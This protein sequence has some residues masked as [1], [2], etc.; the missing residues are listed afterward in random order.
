METQL[1][2][3]INNDDDFRSILDLNLMPTALTNDPISLWG[4]NKINAPEVWNKITNLTTVVVGV[5][6]TGVDYRHEDLIQNMW[7]NSQEIAGNGIDDDNNGYI[8]DFYGYDFYKSNDSDPR[9]GNSHGTHV[10]GI[11][12]AVGNNNLGVVGV[13]PNAQIMALKFFSDSGDNGSYYDAAE[14]IYYAVKLK[15]Q[16]DLDHRTGAN[17][18]VINASFGGTG[19]DSS[20]NNAIKAAENAGILIVAAAGNN[21]RDTDIN[22]FYPASANY[23]NVIAVGA[24]N[25]NDRRAS[26]SNYG[27]T[28]VDVF[29]PGQSIISTLPKNKYGTKSGTSMAAPHVAGIAS[30]L[31]SINNNL[32]PEQVKEALISSSV[33]ISKLNNLSVSD[34]VVNANAAV[35]YVID[36]FGVSNTNN[37][38]VTGDDYYTIDQ[39]SYLSIN[40]I[41]G[42]LANDYDLDNNPLT[43]SLVND[44][45]Q[46]ILKLNSDGSFDYTPNSN[47]LGTDSFI[48]RVNDGQGGTKTGLVTLTTAPLNHAPIANNDNY[49]LS[50]DQTLIISVENGVL[51]NDSDVDGDSLTV[52]LVNN[53][54]KGT[55]VLSN[56]GSFN[57]TPNADINGIDSFTYQASDGRGNFR[58]ATVTLNINPINDAPILVQ[59]INDVM[60]SV[61]T[62][63]NYE[64]PINTFTDIDGDNLTYTARLGNGDNLPNWLSFDASSRTFSGNIP[65]NSPKSL[66]IKV[67]ASDGNLSATDQFTLNV[68]LSTPPPVIGE[69]GRLNLSSNN[70]SVQLQGNYINPVVFVLTPSFNESDSV[71]PRLTNISSNQF[72]VSLKETTG[73]LKNNNFNSNHATENVSYLVLET[74]NYILASGAQLK[75]GEIKANG[76]ILKASKN[77]NW[78]DIKFSDSFEA[79][80][81]VL[82]Q[83]QTN[84]EAGYLVTRQR[85]ITPTGVQIGLQKEE[86]LNETIPSSETIGYLAISQ[87]DG[88]WG[89]NPYL[90]QNTTNAANS[91]WLTEK[92]T[93]FSQTPELFASLSTFNGPDTVNLRYT[94][95]GN[96]SVQF[97]A[98]EEQSLGSE[99]SHANEGL[100]YLLLQG[101]G[102]LTGLAV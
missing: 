11:I 95:L 75:V 28:S 70:Q 76:N 54:T 91:N 26:F 31:F 24:S 50:E 89:N 37:I 63:F 101:S 10:A 35:Q 81:V 80:P 38:P 3:T 71:A 29:A 33:Y 58:N 94:H 51:N 41:N 66:D 60:A 40:T 83:I 87:G 84:N 68:K 36:H 16:Y 77:S 69:F 67:T 74:G 23:S 85:N 49:T 73:F 2:I 17:I 9:D 13:N 12:A 27:E 25:N 65:N 46:G 30:L 44:V 1:Q 88:Y 8:D 55:L 72:T 18:R 53:V 57:Y 4:I 86:L 19:G 20:F 32:T 7:T 100:N 93:G 61:G 14:G 78:S 102:V 62:T 59:P 5:L 21:S 22:P 45:S 82:S 43:V 90:A 98:Q 92:F 48:Y 39:N 99:L 79:N 64:I 34:G 42:V 52:F 97:L 56:N 47:I 15:Q 6:D 96:S